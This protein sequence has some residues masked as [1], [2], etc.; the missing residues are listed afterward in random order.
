MD[1]KRETG[2]RIKKAREDADLTLEEA[3]RR[4]R[5]LLSASRISNYEQGL[6]TPGALEAWELAKALGSSPAHLLCV[7]GEEGMS[8]EE[9]TLLRSWRALPENDRK[10]YARRIEVLALAYREPVPDER[11]ARAVRPARKRKVKA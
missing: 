4:T 6:R 5:G 10:E 3:S 9:A 1:F 11:V 8:P 7:E 2:R